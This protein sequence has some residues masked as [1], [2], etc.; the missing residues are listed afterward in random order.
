MRSAVTIR[1]YALLFHDQTTPN[2]LSKSFFWQEGTTGEN[3]TPID[4]LKVVCDML[5]YL[6]MSFC[7]KSAQTERSSNNQSILIS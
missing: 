6:N 2:E 1:C 7:S 3:S 4:F 5:T